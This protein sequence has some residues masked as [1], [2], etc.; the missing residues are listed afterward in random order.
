MKK[1]CFILL[2]LG[3]L[4]GCSKPEAKDIPLSD[5]TEQIKVIAEFENAATADLTDRKTAAQY[6]IDPTAIKEGYV[7][8]SQSEDK[9]DEVIIARASEQS[10]VESIEKAISNELNARTEAWKDNENESEKIKNHIMRTIDDCV[11]LVIGDE[12]EAVDQVFCQLNERNN[13]G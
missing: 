10:D 9:A 1:I 6:G 8:Y 2:A 3:M 13:I 5:I 7:Y 12:A 11:L 4:A